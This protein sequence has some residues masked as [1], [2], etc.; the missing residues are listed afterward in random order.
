MALLEVR[1]MSIS[2]RMYESGLKQY[3]SFSINNVSLDVDRGEILAIVGSSGSGKSLFAHGIIGILPENASMTGEIL[4]DGDM[5]T[6]ELQEELR[7]KKIAL[8]PQSIS[9]LDPLMKTGKQ[10][11]STPR[12]ERSKRRQRESFK[13]Y[14]LC[15]RSEKLYPYQLS[16][17]MLRRVMVATADQE[18]YDLIIADEPTPGLDLSLARRTLRYFREFADRDKAVMLITHD[19]DLALDV[20]DRIAIFYA[21]SIVEIAPISDFHDGVGSLRHPYTK[22]LYN[23]LPQNGFNLV[24]GTQPFGKSRKEGCLYGPRCENFSENCNDKIP[25]TELRNGM[26][27]CNNAT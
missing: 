16:G 8:V 13:K 1:D 15:E 22:A 18:D 9:Y 10:V 20:A 2:F 4:Y 6:K 11:E 7:G 5:L 14:D 23:A 25:M 12:N 3:N 21:G 19:I 26:V 27:R 17:G 24:K